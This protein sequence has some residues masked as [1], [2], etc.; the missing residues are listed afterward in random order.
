MVDGAFVVKVTKVT[1]HDLMAKM[2]RLV[3]PMAKLFGVFSV[4]VK[5][6]AVKETNIQHEITC[7]KTEENCHTFRGSNSA[8]FFMP[9]F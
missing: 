5:L 1:W 2:T 3:P 7:F 4:K 8:I 6:L 9:P